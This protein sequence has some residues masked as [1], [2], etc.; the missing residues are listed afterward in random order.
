MTFHSY[1]SLPEVIFQLR[2]LVKRIASQV[3]PGVPRCPKLCPQVS[4]VLLTWAVKPNGANSFI[5][6]NDI[7][8][9]T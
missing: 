1:V 6:L 4:G 7:T 8:I 2:T 5:G 9:Y 3:S